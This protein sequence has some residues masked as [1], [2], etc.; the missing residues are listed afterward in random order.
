[1]KKQ[2]IKEKKDVQMHPR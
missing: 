1:M 2:I